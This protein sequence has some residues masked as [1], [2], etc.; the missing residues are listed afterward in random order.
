[1][2]IRMKLG[3]ATM[4]MNS[5]YYHKQNK[6]FVEHTKKLKIYNTFDHEN[7]LMS[8]KETS[9]HKFNNEIQVLYDEYGNTLSSA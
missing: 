3:F 9:S 1:M 8:L 2:T 7:L 5:W 6:A 4:M